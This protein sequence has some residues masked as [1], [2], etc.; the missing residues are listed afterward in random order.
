MVTECPLLMS[1]L[2]DITNGTLAWS[3]VTSDEFG[4]PLM[5]SDDL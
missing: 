5:T 3:C 4:W 1:L 2:E